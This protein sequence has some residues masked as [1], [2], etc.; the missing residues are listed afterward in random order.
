MK[1]VH[2]CSTPKDWGKF[3]SFESVKTQFRRSRPRL[4]WRP[5]SGLA[6]VDLT[7]ADEDLPRVLDAEEVG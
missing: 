3:A 6:R 2:T 7:S 5:A 4:Y 1:A